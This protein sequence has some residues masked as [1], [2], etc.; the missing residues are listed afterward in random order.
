MG[1]IVGPIAA[2]ALLQVIDVRGIVLVSL[3][4]GAIAML[5]LIFV[6]KEI[7]I[8]RRNNTTTIT[9][10]SNISDVLKGNNNRQFVIL[11]IISGILAWLLLISHLFY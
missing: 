8:K 1:A 7:A 4:P 5:I 6:V 3:I 11:L 2:F 9:F 10:F